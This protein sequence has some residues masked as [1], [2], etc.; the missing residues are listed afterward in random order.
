MTD[1]IGNM[2][3]YI[4][5]ITICLT[6]VL[7]FSAIAAMLA[8]IAYSKVIGME[9]STH[10]VQYMPI[11]PM[12]DR[13]NDEFIKKQ[14]GKEWATSEDSVNKINKQHKEDV[15]DYMSEFSVEEEDMKVHS[16]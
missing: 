2:N 14:Q 1:I 8:S 6:A 9:K 16:F 15:D 7:T 10:S 5:L 12:T 3:I 13:E 11:D 4:V